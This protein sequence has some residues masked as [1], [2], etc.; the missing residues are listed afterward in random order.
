[1]Q[2]L[3]HD[4]PGGRGLVELDRAECLRLLAGHTVGRVVYSESAL[5]A[6]QPVTYLLDDEEVL[7][8]AAA[9]SA[10]AAAIRHHVVAF[11]V[12]QVDEASRSGWSV[13]GVG[14]AYEVL[15]PTRLAELM[16]RLP[17]PWG[18]DRAQLALSIPLQQLT[19]RRIGPR[20]ALSA[21]LPR[22]LAS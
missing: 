18:A 14:E 12:D 5:P 3:I 21:A 20:P 16:A 9:D 17:A 15:E 19:G 13:L 11:E 10:L 1:M 2:M 6:A 22:T 8:G 7:F 4:D